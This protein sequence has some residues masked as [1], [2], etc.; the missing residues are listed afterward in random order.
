MG[1]FGAKHTL[2]ALADLITG[3]A[4]PHLFS[5]HT[6]K[7]SVAQSKGGF[8]LGKGLRS[9]VKG[10]GGHTD[11]RRGLWYSHTEPRIEGI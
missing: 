9:E 4:S 11:T 2:L 3:V 7:A 5:P 10:G 6:V 8:W 1:V